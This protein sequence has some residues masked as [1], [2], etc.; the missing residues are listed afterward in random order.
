M[1]GENMNR[2]EVTHEHVSVPM[3]FEGGR[4][5]LDLKP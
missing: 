1:K 3:D 4:A 5:L 2:V